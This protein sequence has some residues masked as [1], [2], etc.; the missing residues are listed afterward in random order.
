MKHTRSYLVHLQY[1]GMSFFSKAL[2]LFGIFACIQSAHSESSATKGLSTVIVKEGLHH[3]WGMAFLPNKD[4]LI[5]ERRG[6]LKLLKHETNTLEDIKGLPR[7]RTG[8]QGGLLDVA[9]DPNY[10]ENAYIYISFVAEDALGLS[11]TEVAKAKLNGNTLEDLEIIFKATPKV[12]SN[13]HF[14]SRIVFENNNTLF[15]SLG[16][17]NRYKENSQ[18]VTDHHGTLVRIH[19]DGSIP[20]DNPFVSQK[21]AAK[22]IYSYGHRNIQGLTLDKKTNNIFIGALRKQHL[23][24]VVMEN[25]KVTAQEE[26]LLDLKQRI[27][28]VEVDAD[29]YI[30]VLT[31]AGNGQLIKLVEK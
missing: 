23:R 20:K 18:N 30:Y 28:D 7:I 27:R 10:S 26:L 15:I 3:P 4:V 5:T 19:S 24:R 25:G 6:S 29:G 13:H 16:E 11:G 8:G 9:L 17:R 31:D 12:K 21:D 22:E 1:Q 2:F 14:G